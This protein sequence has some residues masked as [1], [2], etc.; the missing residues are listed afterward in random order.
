MLIKETPVAIASGHVNMYALLGRARVPAL[1]LFLATAFTGAAYG[2]DK[3]QAKPELQPKQ[4]LKSSQAADVKAKEGAKT[5]QTKPEPK[6]APAADDK[7]KDAPGRSESRT[8]APDYVIGSEDVL[9]IAVWKN[10]ELTKVVN[11]RPDGR[12]SLPL[13]GDVAAAGLTPVELHDAIVAR[14][15]EYQDTAIVSVIVNS[16]NSYRI[17]MLGEVKTPGAHQLKTKTTVIQ[18]IAIAG[19][20]TQYAS[21]NKMVIIRKSPDGKGVRIPVPFDDIVQ[22]DEST[23][24]NLYLLPGDTIFVP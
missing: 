15:K 17:F 5:G 16:V 4:E 1:C 20:F 7:A 14:L 2:L 11:V 23:N 21:R 13:I 18:A 12:I 22:S 9:E 8:V 6:T 24:K 19:G 10:A 3:A